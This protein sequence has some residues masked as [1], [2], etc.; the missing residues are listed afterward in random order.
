[1]RPLLALAAL[2]TMLG[3]TETT[4]PIGVYLET[5]SGSEGTTAGSFDLGNM[6]FKSDVCKD[7]P[8]YPEFNRLTE[9]SIVDFLRAHK[10][11]VTVLRARSDLVYLDVKKDGAV[12]RLRVALLKSSHEAGHELHEAILEH[13][14]GSWGVH[15]ANLA[16]LGPI[17][18]IGQG[19][20]FA[21]ES[22]LAC[23]GVLTMAGRDDTFVIPGGY[24]E[25]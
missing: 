25:L 7:E 22:K 13:G 3:C 16:V 17:G 23:W 11:E 20:N 15:R 24:M 14:P 9:E 6:R 2:A 4:M 5:N 10:L 21:V 18:S 8:L 19:V 1:M 12:T